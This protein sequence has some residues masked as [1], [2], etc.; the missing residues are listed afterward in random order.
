MRLVHLFLSL[1][2][3]HD[4]TRRPGLGLPHDSVAAHLVADAL[5]DQGY[6]LGNVLTSPRSATKRATPWRP[7]NATRAT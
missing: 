4:S 7:V 1:F 5:L 2:P 6:R 3:Q